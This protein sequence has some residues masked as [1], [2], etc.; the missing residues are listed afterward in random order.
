MKAKRNLI[1]TTMLFFTF[2][3]F[4]QGGWDIN[5]IQI[6]SITNSNVGQQVKIDFKHKETKKTIA[7]KKSIRRYLLPIDT[8]VINLAGK[9]T[10]LIEVR[11]IYIDFGFYKE[12]YL[13]CL[14]YKGGYVLRIYESEILEVTEDK[15]K[16]RLKTQIYKT[17]NNS[18][19]EEPVIKNETEWIAKNKL[20]G[21]MI[22]IVDS[23]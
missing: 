17:N 5:Y 13:E 8:S 22:K 1:L 19:Y 4:S 3:V 12:Q 6:D 7:S 11:K 23:K 20:D 9:N 2:N 18:A 14:D 16:F 15:I 10:T 21:V